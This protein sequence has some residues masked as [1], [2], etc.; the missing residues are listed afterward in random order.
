MEDLRLRSGLEQTSSL[1][2]AHYFASQGR[3]AEA[4][5]VYVRAAAEENAHRATLERFAEVL[6]RAGRR[7]EAAR[8]YDLMDAERDSSNGRVFPIARDP[9]EETRKSYQRMGLALRSR[10]IVWIAMQYPL[11]RAAKLRELTAD[12]PEAVLV[13]NRENFLEAARRAPSAKLFVDR[14]AGDFGHCTRDGYELIAE[15]AEKA[16]RGAVR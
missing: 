4:A 11:R 16:V 13:E 14:F 2:V 6:L 8:L 10:G 12:F 9:A 5:E 7:D 3:Q 1:A 15:A